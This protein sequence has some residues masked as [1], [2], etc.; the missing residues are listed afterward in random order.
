MFSSKRT[1]SE[2]SSRQPSRV[3][4]S[5]LSVGLDLPVVK[6]I[7]LIFPFLPTLWNEG[8]TS[9][10][11]YIVYIHDYAWGFIFLQLQALYCAGIHPWFVPFRFGMLLRMTMQ[12]LGLARQLFEVTVK[13]C[14]PV[15][16]IWTPL[17][18]TRDWFKRRHIS[19][20]EEKYHIL[21]YTTYSFEAT[22]YLCWVSCLTIGGSL[23]FFFQDLF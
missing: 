3:V 12:P 22:S 19:S 4:S 10:F 1:A 6:A 11:L 2:L 20:E 13:F 5:L 14:F 18:R 8:H 17:W 9:G 15:V 16:N 21:C 7:L 23:N